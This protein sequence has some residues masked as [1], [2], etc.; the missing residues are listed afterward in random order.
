MGGHRGRGDVSLPEDTAGSGGLGCD[1]SNLKLG[2]VNS[3]GK[4]F[5][6]TA[7]I[8]GFVSVLVTD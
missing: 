3:L 4:N 6:P 1:G 2:G 7:L 8:L 5:T